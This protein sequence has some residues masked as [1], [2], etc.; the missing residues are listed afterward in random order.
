[1]TDSNNEQKLQL[2]C[3]R[4]ASDLMQMSRVILNLNL[5][6][7]CIRMASFWTHHAVFGSTDNPAVQTTDVMDVLRGRSAPVVL[8]VEDDPLLRMLA[9]E[10]IKDAGFGTLEAGDADQAI[11]MLETCSQVAALFTDIDMPGSM[12]G[13]KLAVLVKNR[14]PAIAILVASGHIRL[15]PADLPPESRFLCKPYRAE[16]MI[17]ELHSLIGHAGPRMCA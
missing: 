8:I 7:H 5:Q 10:F 13:L 4:V 12:D 6:A 1:V 15:G 2:E 9:V 11:I 17:A 14:W 3:L 16:A